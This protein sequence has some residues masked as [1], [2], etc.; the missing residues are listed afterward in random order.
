MKRN[1]KFYLLVLVIIS[2]AC[3][4][5]P[6]FDASL[7][8]WYQTPAEKWTDAFPLGNGRLATMCFGGIN[9]ERFQINEE[10]LWAGCQSNP[11][12]ENYREKLSKIQAM[13]LNGDYGIGS[14]CFFSLCTKSLNF[15]GK[16]NVFFQ[17]LI[18]SG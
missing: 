16:S 7:R 18:F 13:V 3:T 4:E 9:T 2:F 11:F 6:E 1:K 14:G 5:K 15:F 12:A 8:L 17:I 10:S